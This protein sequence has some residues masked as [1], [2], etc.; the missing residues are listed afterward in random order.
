MTKNLTVGNP[1]LLI[2]SFAAPL[3]AGNLFQQF[4]NMADVFIVGRTLGVNAL[5]AV[6]STGS[7]NF[8]V[9]GFLINSTQGAAIVTAQRFGAQDLP[10]VRRSFAASAALGAMTTCVL[11]FLGIFFCR[12]FLALLGTPAE[13][14]GA[15]RSYIIV[16]YW[17]MPAALLFN[18]CSSMMRAVGDSRT[19]L[20]ILAVACVLNIIL[21]YTFILVFHTGVE[22][23]AYATV[24]AQLVSGLLCFPVM[25]AR[26]P[27]FRISRSDLRVTAGELRAHARIAVPMGFQMSIIAAGSVTVTFALNRLGALAVAAFTASQKIDMLVNMPLGS[28]GA[29]MATYSAQNYG[30]R[31]LERI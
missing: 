5:A 31:K 1:A 9:L 27:F 26:F 10:G 15:A 22:G 16:I 25:A 28:L 19:P 18:L 14:A 29:A 8:L 24:I 12:P 20:V 21:D 17:G 7:M 23:A 4:Y 2:V 30:A 13:I 6:G 3:F 11:M